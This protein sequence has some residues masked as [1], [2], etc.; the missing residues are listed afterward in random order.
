ME[1]QVMLVVWLVLAV[2]LTQT[3]QIKAVR[4]EIRLMVID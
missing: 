1:M 4:E 2:D 3:E